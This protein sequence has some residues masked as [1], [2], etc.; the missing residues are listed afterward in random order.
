MILHI[1]ARQSWEQALQTGWYRG[2]TLESE[3]FIHCSTPA[4]VAGVANALYAGRRGLVILCIAEDQVQAE[5][6]Y[7]RPEAGKERYPH[8]YGPLNVDA[9]AQVLD[10]TPGDDGRFQLPIE[11][12]AVAETIGS[13][14]AI[15]AES[16]RYVLV[17]SAFGDLGIV[18]R[19][20]E[21]RPR[22]YRV[23]LPNDRAAALRALRID[24]PECRPASC[25]EIAGLGERIQRFLEGSAVAFELDA[26]ALERCP[27]F[28]R[29]VLLAEH[30][31]PRGWVSTYGRIAAALGV[32]RGARAVGGALASNPFPIIIPCHR[33]IR[34]DGRLGGFQ[35]G[36]EMKR[37]LLELEGVRAAPTGKVVVDRFYYEPA[38]SALAGGG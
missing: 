16:S 22:V 9:V 26:I 1:T 36:L 18:W 21:G 38:S 12:A 37:A 13:G 11:V 14:G 27:E 28:Q 6:R 24:F 35:G 30:R 31:I 2:D 25:P 32:P 7:E 10:L 33:A 20:D 15:A 34:S 8:I 3:G 17:P 4:Q 23:F 5:V 29:R 19:E